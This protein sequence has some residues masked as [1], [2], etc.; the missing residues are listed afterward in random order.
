MIKVRDQMEA[1]PSK[2]HTLLRQGTTSQR[3]NHNLYKNQ[4]EPFPDII[5]GAI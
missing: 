4:K 5:S 2:I 1:H 3:Q